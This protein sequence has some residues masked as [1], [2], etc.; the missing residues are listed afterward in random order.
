MHAV[1]DTEL[2]LKPD[3]AVSTRKSLSR[4]KKS[5]GDL[6]PESKLFSLRLSEICIFAAHGAFREKKGTGRRPLILW[7]SLMTLQIFFYFR[8]TFRSSSKI[9]NTVTAPNDNGSI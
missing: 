3:S 2:S 1:S 9:K 6:T 4:K 5:S 7:N 8:V